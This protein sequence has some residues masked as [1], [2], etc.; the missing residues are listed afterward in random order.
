MKLNIGERITLLNILPE[1]GNFETMDTVDKLRAV[2]V[3]GEEEV[4]KYNFKQTE[5]RAKWD[6]SGNERVKIEISPIGVA[7]L[8]NALRDA[9]R[10]DN[11]TI[12]RYHIL[13]R[14]NEED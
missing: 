14:F 5:E 6:I 8:I 1:K 10:S 2:L 12:E 11:L 3:L 4:K 9:D 13:K 7:F